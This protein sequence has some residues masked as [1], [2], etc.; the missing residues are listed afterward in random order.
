[1]IRRPPRSTLFP[2]TTLFRS[3]WRAKVR[4]ALWQAR[5]V[6]TVSDFAA[7]ELVTVLRVPLG[8]IR[9]VWEAPASVYQPSTSPEAIAQAATRVGLP[10][11]ARWFTYVGGFNPHQHVDAIVRAH[12]ALVADM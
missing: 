4:L 10:P 3:R 5:L 12:G 2:Y 1:M 11:G 6:L 9:V 8:R 7:R